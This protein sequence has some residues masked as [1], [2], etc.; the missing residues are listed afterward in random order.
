MEYIQGIL[1]TTKYVFGRSGNT[2]VFYLFAVL[3]LFFYAWKRRHKFRLI[4]AL[5]VPFVI[6][7]VISMLY[8]WSVNIRCLTF[9]AKMVLNVTLLVFVA[10]NCRK[11]KIERFLGMIAVIQAI[12]TLIALAMPSSTLW[13][14]DITVV[15]EI[16]HRLRLFY[17]DAGSLAFTSGLVLMLLIYQVITSEVIW[18]QVFGIIVMAVDLYL[19][20]GM[21]GILCTLFAILA[22]FEMAII[23][24]GS[25]SGIF[26]KKRNNPQTSDVKVPGK[27]QI[28]VDKKSGSTGQKI[29]LYVAI[30]LT[31]AGFGVLLLNPVYS[32]RMKGIIHGT[33]SV[34]NTKVLHP[35]ANIG[36]VLRDTHF[37]G[38]GFGN[39][40]TGF[41]LDVAN[42]SEA[43]KN[44][45]LRIIAEGGVFGIGLVIVAVLALGV[46]VFWY[47]NIKDKALFLYITLYQMTGGYFT[48]PTNFF[49]YGWVIGDCLIAYQQS[50]KSL[51]S[52]IY[53]GINGFK[54]SGE[55]IF[56][57]HLG[58][59]RLPSREGGIEVVVEEITTRLVQRGH[60]IDVYNR[61][62]QHVSG[63]QYNL[64]DYDKIKEYKGV[65]IIR[66]PTIN[67]KG[68]AAVVYSFL[69]SIRASFENYDVIHYH[70]EGPCAF[71]WIP[72][73]FGIKT[74]CT[75]HGLDWN[76]SGKWGS[77]A[78]TFIKYGEKVA[79][80]YADEIIVLSRHLQQY[81]WDN[82][83]RD[84]NFIPNGVNRP[85]KREADKI[86][87]LGL[88]KDEYILFL[89]RLAPEKGVHYL[90]SA[91]EEL[92]TDMKLVIAGGSSDTDS[93]IRELKKIAGDDYR[94]IFTGF[95]QGRLMEEL[96]SNAYVYCLPSDLEGMP[97]S[98]LEAMSYGNCC[99]V[100]D[101]PECTEVIGDKAVTFMRGNI[102]DLKQKLDLLLK[103][104]GMVNLFK[105]V[106]GDY[107]TAKYQ[108]D[109]VIDRT[110][111]LYRGNK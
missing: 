43:Y 9:L 106:A 71:L 65:R 61:G 82:Y 47:G 19:S 1:F 52:L 53:V 12:E 4:A 21:G 37:L 51:P 86:H 60:K 88:K 7:I 66:I 107:I 110:I 56:C 85:E 46:L 30:A 31:F 29:V 70:A 95:V 22:I 58:L 89:A 96:Y 20:Y 75:I 33:D 25:V 59:K 45:F 87:E 39:A 63:G 76:R 15:G 5:S 38:V 109:D 97:V 78:S 50:G 77:F 101:I 73:L 94:I 28:I 16:V 91:F 54:K 27:N 83:H 74:V 18:H 90:I 68:V 67:R 81:F 79:V 32:G 8:P 62:G 72:T 24:N 23:E 111:D 44:S 6:L 14:N 49:V 80:G 105:S 42:A 41:A 36:D 40:N 2:D 64:A 3:A 26:Q 103:D 100:S 69:A 13:G 11:W 92:D 34:L 99:L 57:G 55:A 35:L 102:A 108:W 104:I 84:T 98:L 10:S 17:L 48:D 93:Y